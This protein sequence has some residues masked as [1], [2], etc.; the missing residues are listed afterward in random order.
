MRKATRGTTGG[1]GRGAYPRHREPRLTGGGVS[2]EER[3]SLP[4]DSS[5]EPVRDSPPRLTGGGVSG[6]ERR[7][8]PPD[9]N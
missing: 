7:S 2:G 8:L 3:R 9:S 1:V 6:E 5:R 4:P